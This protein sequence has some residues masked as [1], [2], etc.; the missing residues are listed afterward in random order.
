MAPVDRED[1][2]DAEEQDDER[3]HD[4]GL[5]ADP[6]VQPSPG[7]CAE[8]AGERQDDAEQAE[9]ESPPLKDCRAVDAAEDEDR[10]QSV[11]VKDAG[12]QQEEDAAV[13]TDH[14][15]DGAAQPRDGFAD[16]RAETRMQAG[17]R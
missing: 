10:R 1:A 8:R 2:E 6:V 14:V 17:L 5:G 12:E 9:V 15:G 11:A 3:G 13:V 7:D 4:H 16:R